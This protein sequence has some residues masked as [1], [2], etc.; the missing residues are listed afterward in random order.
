MIIHTGTLRF[1]QRDMC[2]RATFALLR[3][4]YTTGYEKAAAGYPAAAFW[5]PNRAT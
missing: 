2:D 1:A 4:F 5:H 3:S